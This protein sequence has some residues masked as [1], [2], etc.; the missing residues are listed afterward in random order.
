MAKGMSCL[1]ESGYPNNAFTAKTLPAAL[2]ALEPNPLPSGIFLCS[3]ISMPWL[4][5][6]NSSSR[7]TPTPAVFLFG[8]RGS[9]PPSPVIFSKLTP[10]LRLSRTIIS[11]PGVSKSKAKNIK[12][13]GYIC[14]SSRRKNTQFFF[15]YSP[16]CF[17]SRYPFLTINS[18]LRIAHPAAPLMVLC[19]RTMNF[20]SKRGHSRSRPIDTAIPFSRFRC[21]LG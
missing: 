21:S 3:S 10:D 13:T 9:T 16:P 2:A 8:S 6:R 1:A 12:S 11:S 18:A 14:N 17:L 4:L 7:S 20:Q 5:L 19:E 15:H